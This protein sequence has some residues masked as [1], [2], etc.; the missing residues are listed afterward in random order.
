MIIRKLKHSE[1]TWDDITK[2][3]GIVVWNTQGESPATVKLN[4][5]QLFSLARFLTRSMQRMSMKHR[6][7]EVQE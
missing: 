3:L 2:E 6:R 4:R 1:W 7:R 5:V